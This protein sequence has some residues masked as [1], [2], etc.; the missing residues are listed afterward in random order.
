MQGLAD[1]Y[2]VLPATVGDYIAR[3]GYAKI[4]ASHP[5][6]KDA[7]REVNERTKRL[8]SIGGTKSADQL[9]RELGNVLWTDCGMARSKDAS[10]THSSVIPELREKFYKELRV[11]GSGASPTSSRAGHGVADF[12]ELA[13]LMCYDALQ[14]NESCGGHFRVEYQTSDGE[15]QR[16]DAEYAYAAAWEW[17]ASVRR[18]S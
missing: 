8:M 18:P 15:A 13:E 11:T 6:V 1:G 2:F 12:F 10:R 4:D 9:H 5:A 7:E 14:R 3:G 17:R 16:N